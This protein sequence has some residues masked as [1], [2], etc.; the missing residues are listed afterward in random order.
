MSA[1]RKL[2]TADTVIK[3][4]EDYS[5]LEEHECQLKEML[6]FLDETG[7]RG[8]VLHLRENIQGNVF[9]RP[10]QYINIRDVNEYEQLPENLK[11]DGDPMSD[12]FV[13]LR[14]L[15][16]TRA[17]TMQL[18]QDLHEEDEIRLQKRCIIL[19][20][21]VLDDDKTSMLDQTWKTWTGASELLTQL[22]PLYEITGVSCYKG[23][24]DE[25]IYFVLTL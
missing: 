1:G 8:L 5:C 3:L 21:K 15:K 6:Q 24:C 4:F 14:K 12:F 16:S 20:F 10:F 13:T 11:N 2:V 22:S 19:A 9:N 17:L 18:A 25:S 7:G 23:S